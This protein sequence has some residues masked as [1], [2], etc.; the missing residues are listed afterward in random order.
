MSGRVFWM[1]WGVGEGQDRG[2]ERGGRK[3]KEE[4]QGGRT[5]RKGGEGEREGERE[6]GWRGR[7]GGRD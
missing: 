2:W 6:E 1:S 7:E 4:G 5:R 3:D